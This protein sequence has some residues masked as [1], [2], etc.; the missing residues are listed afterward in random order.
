MLEVNFES[1]NLEY[2]DQC[3]FDSLEVYDGPNI[4]STLL[5]RICG[6]GIPKT[7]RS[8]GRDLY[9]VFR[10][11]HVIERPGFHAHYIYV[12]ECFSTDRRS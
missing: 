4:D 1:F 5:N 7:L 12:G 8:S 11:N 9:F 6:N 10:S 2:G 3:E